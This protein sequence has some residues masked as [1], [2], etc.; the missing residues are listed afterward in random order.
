[1]GEEGAHTLLKEA[2][3]YA[4]RCNFS[5]L[6]S[7]ACPVLTL[8]AGVAASPWPTLAKQ[9]FAFASRMRRR[10]RRCL[11]LARE[12]ASGREKERERELGLALQPLLHRFHLLLC[13]AFLP[14]SS[15]SACL[16]FCLP[17]SSFSAC[18][19]SARLAFFIAHI[20][21]VPL[22]VKRHCS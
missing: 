15:P 2:S 6:N 3:V 9:T 11:C 20:N 14:V 13:L 7:C 8:C 10:S 16:S 22:L 4:A 5:T 1:M 17:A 19:F 12:E 18:L 21:S